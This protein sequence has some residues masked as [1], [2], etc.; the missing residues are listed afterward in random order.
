MPLDDPTSS[1][2]RTFPHPAQRDGM[3]RPTGTRETWRTV[4]LYA[5]AIALFMVLLVVVELVRG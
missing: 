2:W 1:F 4:V 3:S 5:L